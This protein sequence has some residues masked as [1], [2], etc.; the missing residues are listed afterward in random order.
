MCN[1]C[2][3]KMRNWEKTAK[4]VEKSAQ[5]VEKSVEKNWKI[6]DKSKKIIVKWKKNW[7]F[8]PMSRKE[9]TPY[10]WNW[11]R[12]EEKGVRWM[13]TQASVGRWFGSLWKLGMGL[14]EAGKNNVN[15][16]GDLMKTTYPYH[17]PTSS[18]QLK[19]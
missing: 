15:G 5:K 8:L 11:E 3:N 10:R 16:A 4:K 14:V 7:L 19:I 18:N 17:S 12:F 2:K 13:S 1:S 9:E 6:I